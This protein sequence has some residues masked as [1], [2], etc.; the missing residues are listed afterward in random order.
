M[1][2]AILLR[3]KK[4][5]QLRDEV[6]IKFIEANKPRYDMEYINNLNYFKEQAEKQIINAFKIPKNKIYQNNGERKRYSY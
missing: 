1:M 4:T 5:Q 6:M 2:E 3:R